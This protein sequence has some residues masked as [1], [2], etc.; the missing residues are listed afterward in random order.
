MIAFR[1]LFE[2]PPDDRRF[3]VV[4][5]DAVAYLANGLGSGAESANTVLLDGY[6]QHG[7]TPVFR[8]QDFYLSLR[9]CLARDGVL[10]ANLSGDKAEYLAHL[11]LMREAFDGR[12]VV[13]D[14]DGVKNKVA[15]AFNS[16]NFHRRFGMPSN[17]RPN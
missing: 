12:V 16:D 7:I 10:V 4:H 15:F 13:L 5:A 1:D 2:I 9:R 14:V 3:R 17:D 8:D 6:D 11:V